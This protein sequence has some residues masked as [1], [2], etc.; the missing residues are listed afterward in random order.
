LAKKTTILFATIQR[1]IRRGAVARVTRRSLDPEKNWT[2]HA[3]A[4]VRS[5][6]LRPCSDDDADDRFCVDRELFGVR[7]DLSV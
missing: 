2:R 6:V 4:A 3:T 7:G 5:L 1:L